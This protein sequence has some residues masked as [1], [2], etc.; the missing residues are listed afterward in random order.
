MAAPN[1]RTFRAVDSEP[2]DGRQDGPSADTLFAAALEAINAATNQGTRMRL[3]G[4][5]AVRH[6]A[7]S[8]ARPPLARTY[9]DYDVV[10]ASRDSAATAR[11]FRSLGYSEDP[12]FNAIHGAQRM[13]FTSEAGFDVDVIVG[14]FQMCHRLDLGADL[15]EAGLTVHPADLLLTKLQIV[16]IEDKDLR[17]ASAILHDVPIGL[18]PDAVVDPIRFVRPLATDW[19]FY[20][21]V[22]RNLEKVSEYSA[23]VLDSQGASKV[24]G[25]VGALVDAMERAQKSMKWKMRA[26]LGE[27]VAW[28]ELPEEV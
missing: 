7:P 25:A 4:G 5:I 11:V 27:K 17:D 12:H 8:A 18:G 10:V 22:E 15:P 19:G 13:I 23:R 9:H 20:H 21:T 26:R 3:L 6:L 16:E 24:H 2:A 14:T 1:A 28:Y